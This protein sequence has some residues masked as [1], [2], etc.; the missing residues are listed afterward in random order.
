MPE[1]EHLKSTWFLD[2]EHDAVQDFVRRH[3]QEGMDDREKMQALYHAVRDGFRYDPYRLDFRRESLKSS[4]LCQRD[5]GYCVEKA[6]LYASTL[7]AVGIPARL[8]F[9]DVRNHIGTDRLSEILGTDL[10]IFH[11]STEV[12]NGRMWVK[13]TP[14]FNKGLCDHLGVAVLEFDGSVDSIFQAFD[15]S[16]SRFMEYLREYGAFNDIPYE[17]FMDAIEIGYNLEGLRG[18]VIDLKSLKRRRSNG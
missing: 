11:G 8:F 14:A 12:W 13:A 10:L 6:A 2:F 17:L 18:Q 7:R 4:H 3:T 16:G 1:R 5:H 9:G 15:T